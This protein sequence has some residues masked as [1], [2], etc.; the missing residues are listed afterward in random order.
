MVILGEPTKEGCKFNSYV[1]ASNPSIATHIK[2][3]DENK[4]IAISQ[5]S[6]IVSIRTGEVVPPREIK[7]DEEYKCRVKTGDKEEEVT[8]DGNL[9]LQLAFMS[10][11][12]DVSKGAYYRTVDGRYV[13]K[14]EIQPPAYKTRDLGEGVEL[15]INKRGKH[16]IPNGNDG[17][18]TPV[19]KAFVSRV[20]AEYVT[21][22]NDIEAVL[23]RNDG[24]Q[25]VLN[26][27]TIR[28]PSD[29]VKQRGNKWFYK[30]DDNAEEIEVAYHQEL[31]QVLIDLNDINTNGSTES[32]IVGT[33]S[34]NING[35]NVEL[36]TKRLDMD[37]PFV[38]GESISNL[39][40]TLFSSS[41]IDENGNVRNRVIKR[42][43]DIKGKYP[44]HVYTKD[45]IGADGLKEIE[46][47]Y[48]R[49]WVKFTY[50]D[51]R[52]VVYYTTLDKPKNLTGTEF[53]KIKEYSLETTA[54]GKVVFKYKKFEHN[55]AQDV[56][57]ENGEVS[58]YSLNGVKV[59]DI[60]WKEVEGVRLINQYKVGDILVKDIEW[61]WSNDSYHVRK[62]ILVVNG[63]EKTITNL[64]QS[65]YAECAISFKLTEEIKDIKVAE[66]GIES[67]VIGA[68]KFTDIKWNERFEIVS[69]KINGE[70][71]NDFANNKR[72]GNL[73]FHIT[74]LLNEKVKNF[75]FAVN[76]TMFTRDADGKYILNADLVQ[77][78][79]GRTAP[80]KELESVGQGLEAIKEFKQHPFATTYID[81]QGN[82]FE[83]KDF[84]NAYNENNEFTYKIQESGPINRILGKHEIKYEKVNR[85]IRNAVRKMTGQP[86]IEY[87]IKV[88]P[89]KAEKDVSTGL[90][91]GGI[92][93][94]NTVFGFPLG[95]CLLV[96]AGVAKT[97][98]VAVRA[99]KKFQI[100]HENLEK[101]TARMQKDVQRQCSKEINVLDKQYHDKIK[102]A[103][104]VYSSADF[105]KCVEGLKEEYRTKYLQIVGKLQ[106]LG[107]GQLQS[108]FEWG[109]KGKITAQNYLGYLACLHQ[110]DASLYGTHDHP[111]LEKRLK[112]I[113]KKYATK[114]SNTEFKEER[115]K[116]RLRERVEVMLQLGGAETREKAYAIKLNNW[117]LFNDVVGKSE[118]EKKEIKRAFVAAVQKERAQTRGEIGNIADRVHFYKSSQEYKLASPK[119]RRELIKNYKK[120]LQKSYATT[121]V[122]SITLTTRYNSKGA[123]LAD[124]LGRD[125]I[126]HMGQAMRMFTA[127]NE[128]VPRFEYGCR[129]KFNQDQKKA[130]HAER[131]FADSMSAMSSHLCSNATTQQLTT[132]YSQVA[133]E[134]DK[135]E[136]EV[137][138]VEADAQNRISAMKNASS[139]IENRGYMFGVE[140]LANMYNSKNLQQTQQQAEELKQKIDEVQNGENGDLQQGELTG[141]TLRLDSAFSEKESVIQSAEQSTESLKEDY[142]KE[143]E[144]IAREEFIKRHKEEFDKFVDNSKKIVVPGNVETGN[145]EER[146]INSCM[147]GFNARE[148]KSE[149][150]MIK[151]ENDE[152]AQIE[153]E[154]IAE[155]LPDIFEAY[156]QGHPEIVDEKELKLRFYSAY[157]TN[158]KYKGDLDE[159]KKKPEYKQKFFEK[160]N[161]YF[162]TKKREK[163]RDTGIVKP[164]EYE[165]EEVNDN[166]EDMGSEDF[167]ELSA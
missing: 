66:N 145:I 57:V 121:K 85:P 100:K 61:E 27:Q 118:E 112:E 149:F 6:E 14:D 98:G 19:D 156:K 124:E 104:K 58:S 126:S 29:K 18:D 35:E 37:V 91:Q 70:T 103:Q 26:G 137:A 23:Q 155:M 89:S 40:Q 135:I 77:T 90:L 123:E 55:I 28:L 141:L 120:G 133:K 59:S 92:V 152:N 41:Y 146:F 99:V 148:Y 39:E 153:S 84:N 159:L 129:E 116:D 1:L 75:K 51:G 74:N 138:R 54:D 34:T 44:K 127:P 10:K 3:K 21:L 151:L 48:K 144:D 72:F 45:E 162:K 150:D 65:Q 20:K 166:S 108:S 63:E 83:V 4:Y 87:D 8:I 164:P 16:F 165:A 139:E 130:Y 114:G 105:E 68:Y 131:S 160:A 132:A 128:S 80:V 33:Y 36:L 7:P 106:L 42:D 110:Q 95:I 161:E 71:I 47:N 9:Y 60:S 46:D 82:K 142:D 134:V 17:N 163:T 43:L 107:E 56:K 119:E 117:E 22:P 32:N 143:V 38:E 24:E 53:I 147:K 157:R 140:C 31:E 30:E 69:C 136:G 67:F 109:K 15:T 125:A 86:P 52:I 94:C 158:E 102:R 5:V 50:S 78:E 64:E 76:S 154:A 111:D 93:L 2:V 97:I 113:N 12:E 81:D 49:G 79:E 25:I 13:K 62:C 73:R 167:E 101:V 96:G 122:E 115:E 11:A 88:M